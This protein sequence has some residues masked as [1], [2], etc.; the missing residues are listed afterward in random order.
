MKDHLPVLAGLS[1]IYS[2]INLGEGW[3][4]L[5][6]QHI[7]QPCAAML[8]AIH[9]MGLPRECMHLRGKAY[10]THLPTLLNL[11][12]LGY[13]A[14]DASGSLALGSYGSHLREQVEA[15]WSSFRETLTAGDRIIVLDDGGYT[16]RSCPPDV[17]SRH[18]VYGI[19]QTS[20][21]IWH[22]PAMERMP[23]INV[24]ASAAKVLIEPR[25]VAES[26]KLRI[27]KVIEDLRPSSVGVVGYGNVGKAIYHHMSERYEAFVYDHSLS[28]AER[29]ILGSKAMEGLAALYDRADVILSSTGRDVSRP[30]WLFNST[31][32]R[33]L[34]S[35]SSGDVEFNWLI[36]SCGPYL[37]EP[38]TSPLQTLH[39]RT[40][41]GHLIRVLRGGMVANFTGESESGPEDLIQMTRGLLLGAVIQ[42]ARD[43]E[44]LSKRKGA[45]MLDPAIQRRVMGLWLADQPEQRLNYPPDVID[46]FT[47]VDW[48]A[49]RSAGERVE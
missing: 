1:D 49:A 9:G 10:S 14:S 25:I 39:I 17:L 47:D 3:F 5:G 6:V 45:I 31:G 32:D 34:V 7:M 26:V 37:E 33:T 41:N 43:R 36:R 21:G 44:K 11:Q 38:L 15:M 16:L 18:E 4:V 40:P 48:I 30:E 46:G 12:K 8:D 2:A 23:V 27:G 24:A 42:I 20:S 29:Q 28:E 35:L 19:E 22:Q 13:I